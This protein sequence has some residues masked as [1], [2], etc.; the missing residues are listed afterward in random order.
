MKK[1]FQDAIECKEE[2]VKNNI[3]RIMAECCELDMNP[4]S[5]LDMERQINSEL[6]ICHF[7]EDMAL[8]YLKITNSVHCKEIALDYYIEVPDGYDLNKWDFCVLWAEMEKKHGEKIHAWFPKISQLDFER[9]ILDECFS[10]LKNG[11]VPFRDIHT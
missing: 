7:D 5:F 9:K 3:I 1:I 11:G 4:A 8:L 6:G 2:L 10:F